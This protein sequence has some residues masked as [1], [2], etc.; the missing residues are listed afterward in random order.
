MG[1]SAIEWTEETWNPVTGCDKVSP[2]CDNCYAER[3][4]LRLL[5]M[6]NQRYAN[7][8]DVTL[9]WDKIDDPLHWKRPRLVF[10][11]SMSDLFHPEVP[12]EFIDRVI[13]VTEEANHHTYQILTKRPQRASRLL[14]GRSLPKNVWIGTSIESEQYIFRASHLREIQASVRFLS[15]EPLLGP[16]PSLA[17]TGIDWVIVG[18]ESGP[19]HRPVETDWVRGVRIWPARQAYRSSSNNGAAIDPKMVVDSWMAEHG[20]KCPETARGRHPNRRWARP[21]SEE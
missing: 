14:A 5:A 2:G 11:N 3:L 16:L 19:G 8:F 13:A 4:A 9:H 18:G 10:V 21:R 15:L 1:R 17:L 20:I 6:G 12:S 7:G